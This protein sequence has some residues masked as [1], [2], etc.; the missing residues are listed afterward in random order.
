[1]IVIPSRNPL[2][3]RVSDSRMI[4]AS[5]VNRV[6]RLAGASRSTWIRSACIKWA[7]IRPCS[8]RITSS[9]SC[10]TSTLCAYWVAAFAAVM[11]ITMMG[12]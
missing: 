10:C 1:M 9:T 8:S 7:N 6:A 4:V 2:T 12:S 3:A 5:V 11:M